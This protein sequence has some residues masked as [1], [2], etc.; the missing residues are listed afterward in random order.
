MLDNSCI[1][2]FVHFIKILKT[3]LLETSQKSASADIVISFIANL[4]LSTTSR[5]LICRQ[6]K[7]FNDEAIILT[8][9]LSTSYPHAGIEES[10]SQRKQTRSLFSRMRN[11]EIL[12]TVYG[13]RY[14]ARQKLLH[15]LCQWIRLLGY[16][17]TYY[18]LAFLS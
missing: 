11:Q 7:S 9:H 8:Y 13:I 6:V 14:K 4:T 18:F 3:H 1:A 15:V 5:M 12:H 10:G 2:R 17:I 16:Q